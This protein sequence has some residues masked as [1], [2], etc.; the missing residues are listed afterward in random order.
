MR[1]HHREESKEQNNV[2]AVYVCDNANDRNTVPG[3][4]AQA[5]NCRFQE[6][7]Y[8]KCA[9]QLHQRDAWEHH[10]SFRDGVHLQIC[11]VSSCAHSILG[12]LQGAPR[13]VPCPHPRSIPPATQQTLIEDASI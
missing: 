8:T 13:N 3:I 2:S 5:E 11:S 9:F 12:N 6:L 7:A 10:C 1:L 4:I